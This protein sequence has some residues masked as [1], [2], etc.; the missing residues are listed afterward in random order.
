MIHNKHFT[1]EEARA[2]LP[3]VQSK[4]MRMVNLKQEIDAL[5]Y[6]L[7]RHHYFSNKSPNGEQYHVKELAIVDIIEELENSGILIK[8]LDNGLIDFPSIRPNGEEVYLCWLLEEDDITYW[9]PIQEGFMG[10]R[11]IDLFNK[12]D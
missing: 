1:L 11:H 5:G 4:V 10:R 12:A 3:D 9:H 2:L 7:Y 6:D 8:G